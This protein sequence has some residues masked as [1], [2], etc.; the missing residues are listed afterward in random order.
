MRIY[1]TY[2]GT[3]DIRPEFQIDGVAGKLQLKWK[4][5][6]NDC[7]E[8][9]GTLYSNAANIYGSLIKGHRYLIEFKKDKGNRLLYPTRVK[10]VGKNLRCDVIR[11]YDG[12]YIFIKGKFKNKKIEEINK[13]KLSDYLIWLGRNTENE[14]TVINILEILKLTYEK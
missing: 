12:S 11:K 7:G 9:I 6:R 13:Q 1:A 10:K 2:N 14:A 8:L 4:A 5:C 3:E